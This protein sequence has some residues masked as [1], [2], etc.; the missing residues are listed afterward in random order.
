MISLMDYDVLLLILGRLGLV[1]RLVGVVVIVVWMVRE[2][3]DRALVYLVFASTGRV[4]FV[5]VVL[6]HSKKVVKYY[7]LNIMV[8]K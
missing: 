5:S 8:N 1:W 3:Y 2:S 6:V 7:L 4:K